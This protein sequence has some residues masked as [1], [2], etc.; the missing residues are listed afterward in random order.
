MIELRHSSIIIHDYSLGDNSKLEKVLSVY[1]KA[2]F[3][4]TW[5]NY[6]YDEPKRRLIIP[7]GFNVDYLA[8]LF[9]DRD[10]EINERAD[11]CRS[12]IFKM[13][14]KCRDADQ[15]RAVDFLLGEGEFSNLKN[16]SQKMLN[17]KTGGGKTFCTINSLS[18]LRKRAMVIVD[19]DKLLKQWKAEFIKH[20]NIHEKEV[21]VIQGSDSMEKIMNSRQELP[22]KIYIATHG[23]LRSYAKDD[24]TRV[25]EFFR[26]VKIG[27]KVF[28]EAHVE[29]KNIFMID[30]FTNTQNTFYL[31]ATPG[32]S[33]PSEDSVYQNSFKHIP[34][35]GLDEKFDDPHL[36]TYYVSYDSKP[37][38]SV[39]AACQT[40]RGFDVKAF[41]D[42]TFGPKYYDEFVS[43]L[44][45]L[46]DITL[47]KKGKTAIIISK[48]DHIAKLA[49]TISHMYPEIDVGI[50]TT[51]TPE[52]DRMKQLDKK[53]ILS[54]EKSLGKAVDVK[55]LRFLI[56]TV[57]TS[58]KIVAD[59]T[60]GRLRKIRD[61]IKSFYF[62]LTD[63]G[64]KACL[65]QR[66]CRKGVIDQ[67]SKVIKTLDL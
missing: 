28:D 61:D 49:K 33:N 62:D 41:S 42:W 36:Y 6:Y 24:W 60:T 10:I 13:N 43:I 20:S 9:P 38:S 23:T 52:K 3:S 48:N 66:K 53:L 15:E 17:L 1:D 27:V 21:Y 63:V 12:A 65:N 11:D 4:Y 32:R 44:G 19:Q 46:L 2:T 54:T 26:K 14:S 30:S 64:F 35:F 51:L 34:K 37:P 55:H 31:T 67:K 8:Y 39:I 40:R 5:S 16:T 22:Y 18:H 57:P 7:R 29:V 58:S 59:Q 45:Q 50:F 47:N 25:S 56:M